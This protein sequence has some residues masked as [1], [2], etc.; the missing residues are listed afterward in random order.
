VSSSFPC[1]SAKEL[2]RFRKSIV[3][4]RA[5]ASGPALR[6]D[7]AGRSQPE[8]QKDQKQ[9]QEQEREKL[10]NRE[11]NARDRRE[12]E[13]RRDEPDHEKKQGK[14]EHSV[15]LPSDPGVRKPCPSAGYFPTGRT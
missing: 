3:G 2:L 12:P 10:R 9:H 15:L 13:Q 5:A 11:R 14:L 1:G 6:D 8:D 7:L 4:K